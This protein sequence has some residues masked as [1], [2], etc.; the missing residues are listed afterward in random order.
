[1]I[2]RPADI[3]RVKFIAYDAEHFPLSAENN[4]SVVVPFYNKNFSLRTEVKIVGICDFFIAPLIYELPVR[5]KNQHERVAT[6][7]E[8]NIPS[9]IARYSSN[10]IDVLLCIIDASTID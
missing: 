6:L 10:V 7:Q 9:F 4:N 5:V 2:E 3:S 1:M 8:V